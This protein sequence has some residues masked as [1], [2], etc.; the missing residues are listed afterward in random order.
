MVPS[1]SLAVALIVIDAGTVNFAPLAGALSDT[2]GGWFDGGVTAICAAA[3]VTV[4]PVLST[5]TAVTA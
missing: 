5:A 4:A 3:D 2:A 1:A